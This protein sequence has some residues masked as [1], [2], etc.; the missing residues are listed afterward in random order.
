NGDSGATFSF[1]YTTST[2]DA[3]TATTSVSNSYVGNDIQT[4][5]GGAGVANRT[6]DVSR[7]QLNHQ[8]YSFTTSFS[9][10][11]DGL[12]DTG[13]NSGHDTNWSMGLG[14]HDLTVSNHFVGDQTASLVQNSG[15]SS[16]DWLDEQSV[17]GH[18]D[19]VATGTGR[20]T[21]AIVDSSS[22]NNYS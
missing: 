15:H 9:H 6:Q 2:S 22:D 20:S 18:H 17:V 7:T 11:R 8:G 13:F 3:G 21:S 14:H 10:T 16:E 5:G 1:S 4:S 19:A 12:T